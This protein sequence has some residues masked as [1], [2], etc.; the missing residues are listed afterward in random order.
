MLTAFLRRVLARHPDINR[1]L[2]AHAQQCYLLHATD[3]GLAFLLQ[4]AAPSLR[5]L[6]GAAAV[7]QALPA[8][9]ARIAG[10]LPDLLAMVAGELDGDALFFNRV[11]TIGGDT[12]AVLALR[13]AVD[14]SALDLWQELDLLWGPL[15]G[16][17]ARLRHQLTPALLQSGL[18]QQAQ[19]LVAG[20]LVSERTGR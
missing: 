11:L 10:R 9:D 16:P 8:A 7:Q 1:R 19:R 17:A 3:L 18:L 4:P 13:N 14:A 15:A 2:G 20:T 12:E 6:L 5:L